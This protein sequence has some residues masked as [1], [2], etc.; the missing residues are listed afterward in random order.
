MA[1]TIICVT[2]PGSTGKTSIIREFTAKHLKYERAKG[3]V[4]GIF[5]MPRREYAVGVTGS[6]DHLDFILKGQRF[7]TRYDGLRVMIVATRTG[8]STMQEVERFAKKAK[9]T[10]HLVATEK[11]VGASKRDAAVRTNVVKIKRLM[12]RQ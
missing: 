9:A 10:L 8:G 6:G 4:L 1:L 12:P 7:L 3:D 5:P 11:L 2:G